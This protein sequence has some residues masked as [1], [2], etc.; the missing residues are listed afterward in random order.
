VGFRAGRGPPQSTQHTRHVGGAPTHD[1]VWPARFERVIGVSGVTYDQAIYYR[2]EYDGLIWMIERNYGPGGDDSIMNHQIAA[3]VP[4]VLA[5]K[6]HNRDSKAYGVDGNDGTS[7]AAPQ[8]AAAA[9]LY[10]QKNLLRLRSMPGWQRCEAVKS[11]LFDKA[12]PAD[13]SLF[14]RGLLN[15]SAALGAEVREDI[16]KAPEASPF[17]QP[18]TELFASKSSR[19]AYQ[20]MISVEAAQIACSSQQMK[21][22]GNEYP[23]WSAHHRAADRKRIFDAL[24]RSPGLSE[25]LRKFV[26]TTRSKL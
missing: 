16:P 18:A 19:T 4:N 24:Y 6:L 13:P 12:D 21:D 20:S 9:A 22:L 5:A 25:V 8:V 23:L 26:S 7:G 2:P 11:A 3:Y 17:F 10:F 14:G 1:T 15:A